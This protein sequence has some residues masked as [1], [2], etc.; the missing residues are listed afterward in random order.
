M[1]NI[2][3]PAFEVGAVVVAVGAALGL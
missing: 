3:G 1:S 2:G